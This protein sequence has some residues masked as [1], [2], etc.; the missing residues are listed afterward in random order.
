MYRAGVESA[1]QLS[2]PEGLL[3]GLPYELMIAAA[4]VRAQPHP[5]G[6]VLP[7]PLRRLGSLHF[8]YGRVAVFFLIL[9]TLCVSAKL[10]RRLIFT[11]SVG[12]S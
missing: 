5:F 8:S 11:E 7:A 9:E 2:A 10:L 4:G 3:G 12:S 1:S 6:V